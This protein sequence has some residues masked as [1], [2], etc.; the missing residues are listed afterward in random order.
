M[1]F[2][3]R[4]LF[5]FAISCIV[6]L[7]SCSTTKNVAFSKESFVDG[8]YSYDF[9]RVTESVQTEVFFRLSNINYSQ[10][11]EKTHSGTSIEIKN[12]VFKIP[13]F[14]DFIKI[15]DDGTIFSPTNS[16]IF[17]K[18]FADGRIF[19]SGTFLMFDQ[20]VQVSEI[21]LV[22][23]VPLESRFSSNMN[24][25]YKTDD[26]DWEIA[27]ELFDGVAKGDFGSFIVD[28][29][30]KFA[31]QFKIELLK[32][33][34]SDLSSA[35]TAQFSANGNISA[36]GKLV[37]RILS[38]DEDVIYNGSRVSQKIEIAEENFAETEIDK[39]APDWFKEGVFESDGKLC[40]CAKATAQNRETAK[41]IAE[42]TAL[43]KIAAYNAMEKHTNSISFSENSAFSN[44]IL[45]EFNAIKNY[46]TKEIFF[47]T[48]NRYAY[49]FLVCP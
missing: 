4:F 8:V 27:F 35:T 47:D 48:K 36:D 43:A 14:A 23:F 33:E 37:Y 24:G 22:K 44:E 25:K 6:F 12:R 11:M 40:A 32:K 38:E 18:A 7:E 34:N 46:T 15:N 21:A 5:F 16:S 31:T 9:Q 10:M 20:I 49:V 19:W 29:N 17:G 41:K 3:R 26:G 2:F 1:I 28:K 39:N 13:E 42:D 30:G 45:N